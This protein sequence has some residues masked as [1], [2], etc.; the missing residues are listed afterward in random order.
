MK[1]ASLGSS[2]ALSRNQSVVT[3]I[4]GVLLVPAAALAQDENTPMPAPASIASPPS[5]LQ[6]KSGSLYS[7]YYSS[8]LPTSAGIQSGLTHLPADLGFG[9][10][11]DFVWSRFTDRSTIALSYT[12]SYV[13]RVRYSSLDALNHSFTLNLN[14]KL[15]PRWTYLFALGGDLSS[16]DQAIFSPTTLTKV[17]SV[18]ST[19]DELAA[20]LM[21]SPVPTN[22]QL[23]TVLTS[24][25]LL[26]SPEQTLLYGRRMLTA[27]LDSSLRY[28]I[29]PR[30]SLTMGVT[31]NRTQHVS[32]NSPAGTQN[33]F[34]ISDTTSGA[35]RVAVS[36]AIS[37]QTQLGADINVN[38]VVS[39]LADV[40]TTTAL[41]NWGRNVGSRWIL[42]AHG[43]LGVSHPVR[44]SLYYALATKPGPA[45]GGS[46]GFKISSHTLLANYDRTVSDMYGLGAS[47]TS[48][49]G[50]SWRWKPLGRGW[51]I[52]NSFGW[53]QLQGDKSAASAFV[54]SNMSGWRANSD[55]GHSLGPRLAV[56]VGY[57]YLDY[58]GGLQNTAYKFSQNAVRIAF[59]WTAHPEA[60]Q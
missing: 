26:N 2:G 48:S 10:S 39:R 47:T 20:G 18:P 13:G 5:G 51:W 7:V 54:L 43:G 8:G 49:V 28:S 33:S 41:A 56:L 16:I 45:F 15:A 14:R 34:L 12:P 59:A 55:F 44:Q 23:G 53:Q 40:Y 17:A 3:A 25:P 19:G 11:A 27:S 52:T 36:Y 46:L 21:G 37:P 32:D 6:V 58:S 30:L 38:R 60:A 4:V 22:T 1:W 24:A 42:Q 9:G 31:G 57:A 35:G 29:S 50:G